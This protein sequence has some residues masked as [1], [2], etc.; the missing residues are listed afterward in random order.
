MSGT[1]GAEERRERTF[2]ALPP[3]RGRGFAQTWWG[4]SWLRAL[5]DT[6]LD[7]EQL[8]QGRRYA[9]AGAVGAV[10]VR[11]GRVTA[12]VRDRDGTRRRCDVLVQRLDDAEWDRLLDVVAGEA[13]H[14]AALL[15]HDLPPRL[16]EDADAAGVALLPG[17]GDLE[18]EC[19]CGAWDHCLHT[20]AVSYQVARL[21]DRDP[22]LL[23]LVRGRDER[24]L[25]EEVQR[26]NAVRADGTARAD[27][28]APPADREPA[29]VPADE[30]YALGAILPPLPAVPA[31]PA[32]P[33]GSASLTGGAPPEPGVDTAALEF[34]AA[35]AADA[36]RR[37]LAGALAPGHADTVVPAPLTRWQDAV[38]LAAARPGP[39][40]AA[41]LAAGCGRTPS[42]LRVAVRAWEF[43][44]PEGVAVLEEEWDPDPEA[45]ARARDLVAAAWADVRGDGREE[46]E[47]PRWRVTRNRWT[48][49]GT[50]LQLRLGRDGRWWPYRREG[51][52]WW[53][54]GP[55]ERDP[56]AALAGLC[57]LCQ[58][59]PSIT[60]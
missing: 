19:D 21:L 26:R 36:A 23:L 45:R 59:S 25:L 10:S 33:G 15:D 60:G 38:R 35:R 2:E 8:K 11:P 20:A 37:M 56:A 54:A 55:A 17:I 50:D 30:A 32:G 42:E 1:N 31:V 51:G 46:G 44:G 7:S 27:G 13:G 52:R 47:R 34:L 57:Q 43:G 6:A 18:P 5:E 24:S 49:A 48:A 9:R 58:A 3:A 40:V 29:G 41:R 16:A 12:V 39:D 28:S 14:I 22:C 53:P 4:Q